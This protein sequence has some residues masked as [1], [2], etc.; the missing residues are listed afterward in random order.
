[1]SKISGGRNIA[2]KI[3][4]SHFEK[5]L[6]F[7][8]DVLGLCLKKEEGQTTE[9]YSASFGH[10]TLWFDC[11]DEMGKADV[12]L[13]AYTTNLSQSLDKISNSDGFIRNE[14]EQLPSDMK[15]KWIC[16][17]CGNTILLREE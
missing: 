9:S 16:D 2:L 6:A 17:P 7:Y 5:T 12:W 11:V 10:N 14:I 8:R 4:R 1:M 3:P 13:E 15:A